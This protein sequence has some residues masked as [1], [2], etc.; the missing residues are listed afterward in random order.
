MKITSLAAGKRIKELNEKIQEI[1]TEIEKKS[2]FRCAVGED[3]KS[4]Q[5]DFNLATALANIDQLEA[6]MRD[7]KHKLNLFNTNTLVTDTMTIDQ[8]LIRLPQLTER[9]KL[10]ETMAARLPKTRYTDPYGR[11]PGT[12]IDYEIANYDIQDAQTALQQVRNELFT[13][14]EQLNV[15]NSTKEFDI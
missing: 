2:V 1:R 10:L 13:L 5:P 6:E 3:M 9:K 4:V 12:I 7:L 11:S 8:A 14:Q 15:I